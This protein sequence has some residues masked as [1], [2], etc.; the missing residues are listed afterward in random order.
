MPPTEAMYS[1]KPLCLLADWPPVAFA[2]VCSQMN[3]CR[4]E[5]VSAIVV[6]VS[7]FETAKIELFLLVP[8]MAI[9]YV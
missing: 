8:V 4:G 5:R 6:E 3:A 1:V 9:S 7:A 2:V